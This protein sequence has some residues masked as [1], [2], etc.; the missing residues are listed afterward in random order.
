MANGRDEELRRDL[1]QL[2]ERAARLRQQS[3]VLIENSQRLV[4]LA[5]QFTAARSSLPSQGT[6]VAD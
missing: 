5:R 3:S 1:Q 4:R 2:R 6:K